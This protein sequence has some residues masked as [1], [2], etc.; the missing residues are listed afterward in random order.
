M[1]GGAAGLQIE[2]EDEDDEEIDEKA[3]MEMSKEE[4]EAIETQFVKLY[5][6][7]PELQNAVGNISNL[8]LVQKYQILV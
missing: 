8:S 7:L 5:E 4:I 3:L 2:L 6:N 1:Q